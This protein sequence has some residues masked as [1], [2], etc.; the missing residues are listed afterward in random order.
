MILKKDLII[1]VLAT[2]CLTSILFT[3][4]PIRSAPGPGEYDPWI[5][6]NDDGII[7]YEDLFNLASRY[8]TFGTSINKTDLLLQLQSKIESLNASVLD[9]EARVDTLEAVKVVAAGYV[10]TNGTLWKGYNVASSTWNSGIQRYEISITGVNY[11]HGDY[12]TI[13]TLLG[14]DARMV[15]TGSI[16]NK[17]TVYIYDETGT[18]VQTQFHFMVYKIV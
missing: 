2:F 4:I 12:V 9:L 5:D 1:A 13:V 17:L 11:Y 8:G 15:T 18:K 3:A 10:L 16:S 6:T 7:N 14:T